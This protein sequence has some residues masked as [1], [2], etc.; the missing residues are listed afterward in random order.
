MMGTSRLMGS[1]AIS[2]PKKYDTTRYM[3]LLC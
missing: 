2:F 1:S 3:E